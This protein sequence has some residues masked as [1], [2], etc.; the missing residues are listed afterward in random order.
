[1][2]SSTLLEVIAFVLSFVYVFDSDCLRYSDV[3]H[4]I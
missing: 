1:M 4:S 2:T 3:D